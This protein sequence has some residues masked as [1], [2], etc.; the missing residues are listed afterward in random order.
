MRSK[1]LL[2]NKLIDKYELARFLNVP[3]HKIEACES[4]GVLPGVSICGQKKYR[5]AEIKGMVDRGEIVLHSDTMKYEN[6]RMMQNPGETGPEVSCHHPFSSNPPVD[7]KT[8]YS[9]GQN[10]TDGYSRTST[11]ETSKRNIRIDRALL[12]GG[13]KRD[14][15]GNLRGTACVARAGILEYSE[16]GRIIRELIT[17][18][19]LS[20]SD[21]VE[22]LK[23]R[24][25]TNNH[26]SV[27]KITPQNVKE[28][29]VGFTGENTRFS[30]DLLFIAVTVNDASAINDVIRGKRELSCGYTC[31][32]VE[33]PGTWNGQ[34]YDR[35]QINRQYNHVAI[36]DL[37]R[38]GPVASLHLD[39][40]D[41]YEVGEYTRFDE[42]EE[43]FKTEID[44][45][46]D[47]MTIADA[48]KKVCDRY[49]ETNNRDRLLAF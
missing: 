29:Q 35:K 32:L 34:R 2:D 26:P 20:R 24:P 22:T 15:D 37:G 28:F 13:I 44:L 25:I 48:E 17:P 30:S 19:E 5:R 6:A 11:S 3:V 10:K 12:A 16:G 38:A 45:H 46:E 18:E 41:V 23:M 27:K 1:A 14:A 31:D 36:C 39:S 43:V 9:R 4:V 8:G 40:S 47:F 7:H 33:E 42:I 21:S 49:K